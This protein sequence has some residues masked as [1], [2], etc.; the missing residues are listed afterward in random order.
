MTYFKTE[1]ILVS[2]VR[3]HLL[4]MKKK[5]LQQEYPL[6]VLTPRGSNNHYNNEQFDR[7]TRHAVLTKPALAL[8]WNVKEY[9]SDIRDLVSEG[10]SVK[11][12][13]VSTQYC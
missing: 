10:S 11:Q 8:H 1:S 2:T 7:T 12:T 4:Q 6:L 9:N 3:S 13:T 5:S